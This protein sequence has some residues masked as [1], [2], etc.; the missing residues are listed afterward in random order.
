VFRAW[1]TEVDSD[2]D[3]QRVIVDQVASY[4]ESR[5]ERID[6]LVRAESAAWG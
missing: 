3:R 4:T 2:A 5:L 6:R 1:W